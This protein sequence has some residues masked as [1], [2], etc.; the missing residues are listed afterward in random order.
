MF[1]SQNERIGVTSRRRLRGHDY[2]EPGLY[3]VTICIRD[4][5]HRLG[6]ITNDVFEPLPFGRCVAETWEQI[7]E[8]FLGA[9]LDEYCVMPNHF[10]GIVG[11]G[12]GDSDS[13]PYPSV[14]KIMDWFKSVTTVEYIRGVGSHGWPRYQK[15]LWLEGYHDHIIRND[16]DLERIRSYIE[17]NAVNWQKDGFYAD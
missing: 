16:R 15:H 11:I 12:I 17:S 8:R 13:P 4:K 14:P 9:A 10:H 1:K 6:S 2:S 3:F 7:P 5:S